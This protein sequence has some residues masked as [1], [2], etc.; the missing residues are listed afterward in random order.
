MLENKK[1]L[2]RNT[3]IKW[4][5]NKAEEVKYPESQKLNGISFRRGFVQA[6]KEQGFQ[7]NEYSNYCRWSSEACANRY[8]RVTIGTAQVFAKALEDAALQDREW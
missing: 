2:D 8:V 3:L 6:I 4:V 1:L 7:F 5:R